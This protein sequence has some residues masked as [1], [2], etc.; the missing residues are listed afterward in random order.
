MLCRAFLDHLPL[1]HQ[2]CHSL[3]SQRTLHVLYQTFTCTALGSP[4]FQVRRQK[5]CFWHHCRGRRNWLK[6]WLS[7]LPALLADSDDF[8]SHATGASKRPTQ[9]GGPRARE[10]ARRK[11]GERLPYLTTCFLASPA[12]WKGRRVRG[13]PPQMAIADYLHAGFR[14]VDAATRSTHKVNKHTS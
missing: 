9:A 4:Y 5:T 10:S 3:P 6:P 7:P 14:W 11:I 1:F 8:A 12:P 13:P 2:T